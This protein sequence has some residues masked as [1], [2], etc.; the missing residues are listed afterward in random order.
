MYLLGQGSTTLH[1][2]WFWFSVVATLCL[3]RE[4]SL[5]SDTDYIYPG[6]EEKM[7]IESC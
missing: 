6:C 4:I 7:F 2:D 1:F 5:M 3:Q